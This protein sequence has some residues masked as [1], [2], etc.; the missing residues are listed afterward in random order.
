MR[1]CGGSVTF[2][3]PVIVICGSVTARTLH[4]DRHV[5]VVA[6]QGGEVTGVAGQGDLL[7]RGEVDPGQVVRRARWWST[8]PGR[9][10]RPGPR[11]RSTTRCRRSR[12][13]SGGGARGCRGAS[14]GGPRPPRSRGRPRDRRPGRGRGR[15]EPGRAAGHRSA[16]RWTCRW[17]RRRVVSCSHGTSRPEK[18]LCG[19]GRWS[20]GQLDH[21]RLL[22]AE[23]PQRGLAQDALPQREGAQRVDGSGPARGRAGR[24]EHDRAGRRSWRRRARSRGPRCPPAGRCSTGARSPRVGPDMPAARRHHD[25][26]Q[27]HAPGRQGVSGAVDRREQERPVVADSTVDLEVAVRQA[28]HLV[29]CRSTGPGGGWRSQRLATWVTS[30]AV[31]RVS[32]LAASAEPDALAPSD[33][34]GDGPPPGFRVVGVDQGARRVALREPAYD[35]DD[36]GVDHPGQRPSLGGRSRS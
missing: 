30:A 19:R 32:S 10:P 34:L 20:A 29:R 18:K 6:D 5:E 3:P 17:R 8:G 36:G 4:R 24:G 7:G 15:P 1:P 23:E 26:R 33:G 35:V 13:R 12:R 14:T 31:V 2:S 21:E 16:V 22:V 11:P 28:Q 27:R 25:G 9:A